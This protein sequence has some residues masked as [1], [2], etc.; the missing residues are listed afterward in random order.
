M[1]SVPVLE[2]VQY[3]LDL[4]SKGLPDSEIIKEVAEHF[5]VSEAVAKTSL[6][7]LGVY[8]AANPNH[9]GW[10][11]RKRAE[12]I[13]AREE[14]IADLKGIIATARIETD[15]GQVGAKAAYLNTLLKVHDSLARILG[16]EAPIRQEIHQVVEHPDLVTV[17]AQRAAETEAKGKA[18]EALPKKELDRPE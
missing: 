8:C 6:E 4:M 7:K 12:A 9:P 11:A 3:A 1:P 5:D 15:K 18:K 2:R 10:L 13:G 14:M 17:L 16:I